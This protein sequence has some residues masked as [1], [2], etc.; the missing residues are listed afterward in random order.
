MTR[1]GARAKLQELLAP[2]QGQAE[3]EFDVPDIQDAVRLLAVVDGRSEE[4][5]MAVVRE[6]GFT[7]LMPLEYVFLDFLDDGEPSG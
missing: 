3:D 6:A 4:L 1:A 7:P 2:I 5:V